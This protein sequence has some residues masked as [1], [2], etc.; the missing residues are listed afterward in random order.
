MTGQDAA[1]STVKTSSL[2]SRWRYYWRQTQ[3]AIRFLPIFGHLANCTLKDHGSALKEFVPTILFGTATF[4]L[5]AIILAGFSAYQGFNFANLLYVTTESGQLFVFSVGMLGPILIISATDPPN[6][7]QFPGRLGHFALIVILGA[8]ASGFY[9]IVLAGRLQNTPNLINISYL[10]GASLL[11]AASVVVMRYITTVYRKST[12]SADAEGLL[13]DPENR[14]ADKFST[15]HT[16]D[17]LAIPEAAI[18]DEMAD[19]F[20]SRG[21]P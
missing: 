19:R 4:W 20:N 12:Q 16:F 1:S 18:A 2:P 17:P 3:A 6:T 10:Y 15:R 7:K 8:L 14:F 21:T 5:T 11:I 9:A 13:K